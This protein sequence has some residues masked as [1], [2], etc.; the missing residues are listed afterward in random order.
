MH[1]EQDAKKREKELCMEM[2]IKESNSQ[3][4]LLDKQIQLERVKAEALALEIG[5][6]HE[7]APVAASV[8]S[9]A[10]LPKLPPF[11][12]HQPFRLHTMALLYAYT[13]GL[14]SGG[15]HPWNHIYRFSLGVIGILP[16]R[17]I[18]SDSNLGHFRR[19]WRIVFNYPFQYGHFRVPAL[20][21]KKTLAG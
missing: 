3:M 20:F 8:Q 14:D 6:K 13:A 17:A 21:Y 1:I 15:V 19:L 12:D 2:Q 7:S 5:S 10:K 4:V 11:N 18:A 9:R 16:V